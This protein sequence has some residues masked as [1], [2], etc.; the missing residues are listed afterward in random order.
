MGLL[1]ENGD[2]YAAAN[3][4]NHLDNYR[5][6]WLVAHGTGDDNVHAQNTWQLINGL[7]ERNMAFDSQFYP[8]KNHSLPGVHYHLYSMMTRFIKERL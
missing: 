3:V 1:A 2:G 4:L 8:N 5:G 6:N 7:I